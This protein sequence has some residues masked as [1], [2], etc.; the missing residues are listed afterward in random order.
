MN[1]SILFISCLGTLILLFILL[2]IFLYLNSRSNNL[3]NKSM[4]I[5]KK[6]LIDN[7]LDKAK[8]ITDLEKA[9][10]LKLELVGAKF[11]PREF[12]KIL[13]SLT[14]L[15]GLSLSLVIGN[16]VFA[17]LLMIITYFIPVMILDLSTKKKKLKM[18][19]Q[20]GVAIRF[21][22][23]EYI[24]TKSIPTSISNII[25]KLSNP[26]KGEFEKLLR[27]LLTG[28]TEDA[29]N[30][31]AKR[32]DNKFSY[33]FAKLIISQSS[34]GA[35]FGEYLISVSE[36]IM[37][38]QTFYKENISELTMT[39]TVNVI[40][41]VV[42]L[43]SVFLVSIIPGMKSYFITSQGQFILVFAMITSFL[44]IILG[45]GLTH[46]VGKKE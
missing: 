12:T 6:G 44:S 45:F 18:E 24:T 25:P 26:I 9:N 35:G 3:L 5:K 43:V 27:E 21:F 16:I 34:R 42:L 8:F 23:T 33:V 40:L 36:D 37:E 39:R 7:V 11:S 29:F 4:K 14:F 46:E 32:L 31:F 17:P 1:S 30:N 22:N 10:E 15:I 19:E 20:L 13:F 38:E 2:I 28:K 41:N